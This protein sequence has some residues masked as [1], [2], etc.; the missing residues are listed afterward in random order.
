M[1]AVIREARPHATASGQT[2]PPRKAPPAAWPCGNPS[3]FTGRTGS[4]TAKPH[5]APQVQ[6]PEMQRIRTQMTDR[7]SS[8]RNV[9]GSHEADCLHRDGQ[10]AAHAA[11]AWFFRNQRQATVRSCRKCATGLD[12]IRPGG[13][14]RASSSSRRER[15]PR[16]QVTG[17][18][19]SACRLPIPCCGLPR[20]HP[21]KQRHCTPESGGTRKGRI[22]GCLRLPLCDRRPVPASSCAMRLFSEMPSSR[23]QGAKRRHARH[24]P[25]GQCTRT[26]GNL[27][28]HA[29]WQSQCFG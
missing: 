9:A 21:C 8:G 17:H 12:W 4:D 23:A 27:C 16:P 19:F 1:V 18:K 7:S 13:D 11:I 20:Q 29:P 26:N 10:Q 6:L 24:V 28:Q 14:F 3:K 22:P 25:D 5:G 15:A 2:P